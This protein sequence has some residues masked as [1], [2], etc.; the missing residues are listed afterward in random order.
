MWS[1]VIGR[2]QSFSNNSIQFYKIGSPSL[3]DNSNCLCYLSLC[4][5][6][7][8]TWRDHVKNQKL[9]FIIRKLS[10][11]KKIRLVVHRP[12]LAE[13]RAYLTHKTKAI[14]VCIF[15]SMNGRVCK[16]IQSFWAEIIQIRWWYLYQLA[17]WYRS[18]L[19]WYVSYLRHSYL[20]QVPMS[21]FYALFL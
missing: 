4:V 8:M 20:S 21:I 7:I 10:D 12:N 16:N 9:A 6:C 15:V 18:K 1:M 14:L 17:S 2:G 5:N 11:Q 19:Y 3:C 13:V